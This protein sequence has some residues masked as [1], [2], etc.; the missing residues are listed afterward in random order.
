MFTLAD[1]QR[2]DFLMKIKNNNDH[3]YNLW[4]EIK[5]GEASAF[6]TL[7]T[8]YSKSLYLYGLKFTKKTHLIEDSIQ[9]LFS[10]IM[11]NYKRLGNTDNI[12][13]YL[14]SSFRHNLLRCMEKEKKYSFEK[15]SEYHFEILFSTEQKIIDTEEEQTKHEMLIRSLDTLSP[16][17]KEAIYLRYTSGM[18]YDEIAEIMK[19]SIEACR[20]IIYRA[21]K[22]LREE[23]K[24]LD[25]ILLLVLKK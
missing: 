18:E 7:Y 13:V 11:S 2:H 3:Q 9:E 16:R 4:E 5:K 17:Q 20:N 15:I 14:M 22:S 19:M 21:I 25:I 10:R 24:N 6:E 8:G 12:R 1:T 23:I